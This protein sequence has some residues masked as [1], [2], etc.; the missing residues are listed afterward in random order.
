MSPDDR[1]HGGEAPEYRLYRSR[2]KLLPRLPRAL[3]TPPT[4]RGGERDGGRGDDGPRRSLGRKREPRR[5]SSLP[6]SRRRLFKWFLVWAVL[7]A[8]LSVILFAVSAQL[9]SMKFD[10]S[11]NSVLAGGSNM[12]SEAKTILVVGTD[13]R[14]EDSQEPGAN[15]G[16]PRADTLM[17]MRTGG[18]TAAR[19]SIPRDSFAE[20][21]GHGA[22]KINA[23]YALGGPALQVQTV[24]QYLG[25]RINHLVEVDFEGFRSF[26]DALGGVKVKV[27][28]CVVSRINGG[29][30]NGGYTLRLRAGTH[31][32]DG[33][34]ALALARTRNN[35][36]VRNEDDR[37]RARRQQMIMAG[38]KNRI[39]SPTRFP[40][41]F[42]RGPWIG[43][44]APKAL[45]S[46]MGPLTMSQLVLAMLLGGD[47]E[48]R[49]LR[50]SAPGP[51][52]SLI[53][54]PEERERSASRLL[55]D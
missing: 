52:G 19:L 49:V 13:R 8:L 17:L 10:G 20:I 39:T 55:D 40:I 45:V 31:T 42:I 7:W 4:D 11:A 37:T 46:N 24:E 32:L 26:I 23:A 5:R 16:P 2:R 12:V 33:R 15:E 44:A 28:R 21:P 41:N 47:A 9:Q 30:R 27:G 29:F 36:C 6:I 38:I 43:W 53:V 50:P 1:Q 34:Q 14:P 18:G 35:L 25:V 51:G 54:S 3:R 48:T 22:Q